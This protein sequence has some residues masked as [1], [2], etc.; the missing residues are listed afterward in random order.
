MKWIRPLHDEKATET[1][2]E[3]ITPISQIVNTH[4]F[5]PFYRSLAEENIT[6]L[7]GVGRELKIAASSRTLSVKTTISQYAVFCAHFDWSIVS[8]KAPLKGNL[9]G[10]QCFEPVKSW[11][12][13]V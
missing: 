10:A 4:G 11:A 2:S 5:H 1:D 9:K 13:C 6:R 7:K 3:L 12:R 8:S